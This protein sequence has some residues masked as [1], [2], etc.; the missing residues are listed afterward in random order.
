MN[1]NSLKFEK[2]IE[3]LSYNTISIAFSRDSNEI[4]K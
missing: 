2:L 3:I 4:N 1:H